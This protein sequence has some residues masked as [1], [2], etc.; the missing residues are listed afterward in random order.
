VHRP[1]DAPAPCGCTAA[2][3]PAGLGLGANAGCGC[4]AA[5]VGGA[6]H[7]PLLVGP[8][9]H[10]PVP[11]RPVVAGVAGFGG[12]RARYTAGGNFSVRVYLEGLPLAADSPAFDITPHNLLVA[13]HPGGSGVDFHG[14]PA[15]NT[16]G[17]AV[18]MAAADAAPPDGVPDGVPDALPF[19]AQPAVL[20]QADGY[21]LNGP[22]GSVRVHAR[23]RSPAEGACALAG[24]P[25]A[26]PSPGGLARFTNLS[27][28]CD[29][30][31][32]ALGHVLEFSLAGQGGGAGV[33]PRNS[34]R[35]DSFA[36]PAAP[37]HL[38]ARPGAADG[39]RVDVL[40]GPVSRARPL[41]GLL[42]SLERCEEACAALD[43]DGWQGGGG[44]QGVAQGGDHWSVTLAADAS[45]A[46]GHYDGHT[47]TLVRGPGAGQAASVANYSGGAR[48]AVL[49]TRL[50]APP[51][52]GTEYHLDTD[53]CGGAC[54]A[55]NASGAQVLPLLVDASD[56]DLV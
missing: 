11:R 40:G 56:M 25:H 49:A 29:G 46:D 42:V 16:D 10:A 31:A 22:L 39:F 54:A 21:N 1:L 41:T 47:L 3:E 23:L 20:L 2:A 18:D 45:A 51:G 4:S 53:E 19:V 6:T 27:V 52:A 24:E 14:A 50:A 55:G 33:L 43:T 9:A 5:V 34:T 8:E 44:E 30:G 7:A 15:L 48:R 38:A 37:V 35:F 32:P 12:L 26:T 17:A 28:A 36:A 13:V